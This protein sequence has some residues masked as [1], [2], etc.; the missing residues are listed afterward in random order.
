MIWGCD[1]A[2]YFFEQ[3]WTGGISLNRLGNFACRDSSIWRLYGTAL[4]FAAVDTVVASD[5]RVAF[6]RFFF[7][8]SNSLGSTV[9]RPPGGMSS[10]S[11]VKSN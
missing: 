1:K 10:G 5:E 4:S 8:L 9:L 11:K 3:D 2:E 6:A 7:Q